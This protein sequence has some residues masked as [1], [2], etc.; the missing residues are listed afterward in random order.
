MK[1]F[2]FLPKTKLGK[3]SVGFIV[4]F[5]SLFTIFNTIVRIQGSRDDQTFFDNPV[6]SIPIL[7]AGLAG[8]SAFLTG[9]VSIFKSKEC[10]IIVFVATTFGLFILFFVLGEIFVP[11]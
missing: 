4:A 11:H 10:S 6:L 8:I 9:I 7:L 2:S 1:K 5:F 3:W